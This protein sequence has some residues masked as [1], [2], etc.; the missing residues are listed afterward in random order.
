MS[1][2]KKPKRPALAVVPAAAPG[3]DDKIAVPVGILCDGLAGAETWEEGLVPTP[4]HFAAIALE[5]LA[6]ELSVLQE[7][8]DAGLTTTPAVNMIFRLSLR[9]RAASEAALVLENAA[10]ARAAAE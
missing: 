8:L 1:A 10:A 5:S 3:R 4:G 6:D 7:A 2:A 9:A